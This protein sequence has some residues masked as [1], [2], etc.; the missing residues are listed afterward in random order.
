M[1]LKKIVFIVLSGISL[2]AH[3]I[4]YKG[5]IGVEYDYFK[6]DI[7]DKRD[8]SF[9]FRSQFEIKKEFDDSSIKANIKAIW[10]KEDH[11][12]RY[13]DFRELYYKYNFEN[14][15]FLIGKNILFWGALEVYNITDVFNTKDILDDPFD[16]DKKLGS[17]NIS[18][19]YFFENSEISFILKLK[20]ED[21]KMQEAESVF[22]FLPLEYESRLKTEYNGRPSFFVKYSGSGEDIQIDYAFIYEAG[23]DSWRYFAFEKGKLRQHA[24]WVNKLMG[25]MSLVLEDTIYKAEAAYAISDDVKI[26]DYIHAGVGVEHTLY[27]VWEKKDLGLLVEYYRYKPFNDTKLGVKEIGQIFQ[28]DLYLGTRFSFND[29]SSS[30]ILAG[31]DFDLDKSEKIYFVKYDT[32]IFDKFKTK[33]EYQYLSPSDDSV[34]F[35][36]NHL[37]LSVSY[38]F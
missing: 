3:E 16:Y 4:E 7:S 2:F 29:I 14:S 33:I 17:W 15:E 13:I 1:N 26:S 23:Y 32:R 38:Y 37:K 27:G 35:K 6:H 22:N 24:Y 25:Y 21:Q 9:S 36:T 10:D 34:F 30:E 31:I 28:N 11:N 18:W 12:R 5:N 19:R 8:S 20:E